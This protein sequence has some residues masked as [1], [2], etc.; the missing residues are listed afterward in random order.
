MAGSNAVAGVYDLHAEMES[1]LKELQTSGFDVNRLSIVGKDDRTE[2]QIIGHYNAGGRMK[3]WCQ[4]GNARGGLSG[5]RAEH[6]G[7]RSLQRWHSE[8]LI[9]EYET[10]LKSDKFLLVAH[11][12]AGEMA[13]TNSILMTTGATRRPAR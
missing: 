11:G 13:R 2:A 7:C 4:P 12:T 8:N 3:V 6:F 1:I 5:W 9:V 10:A